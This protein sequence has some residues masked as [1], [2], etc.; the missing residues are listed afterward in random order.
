M[1]IYIYIYKSKPEEV[2]VKGQ[3]PNPTAL[4]QLAGR[5][6]CWPQRGPR[7]CFIATYIDVSFI[8][9]LTSII[10][11][12]VVCVYVTLAGRDERWP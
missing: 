3:G 6:E 7:N 12:Y 11:V 10:H 1:Y 9:I 2:F 5:D 8:V 4:L